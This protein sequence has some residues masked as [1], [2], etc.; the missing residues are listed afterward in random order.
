MHQ[1]Q[2]YPSTI[3][4]RDI[5]LAQPFTTD[6]REGPHR[7]TYIDRYTGLQKRRKKC[8][9]LRCILRFA[10]YPSVPEERCFHGL[11]LAL[12]LHRAEFFDTADS[13]VLSGILKAVAG[14]AAWIESKTTVN[15]LFTISAAMSC[16]RQKS[17][18]GRK[19]LAG[20]ATIG[21]GGRSPDCS[22]AKQ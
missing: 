20:S 6:T 13:E 2:Q 15:I 3:A 12:V 8:G 1:Q 14:T 5:T 16:H 9:T 19:D 11:R 17:N 18:R 7:W 10:L 21:R 4:Q 22:R